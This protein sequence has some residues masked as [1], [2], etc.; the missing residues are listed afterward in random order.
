MKKIL[1]TI[2]ISCCMLATT[3]QEQLPMR[4]WYDRPAAFFEESLPIGNGKLGA[5][6]YGGADVDSIKLND[7]TLWTGRPYD[8]EMDANANE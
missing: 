1:S 3:A 7:I 4:L 8:R 2:F 5:L 6:V